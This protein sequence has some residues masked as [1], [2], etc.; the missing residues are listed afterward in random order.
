M[1]S[2]MKYLVAVILSVAL[3]GCL[4]TPS[5]KPIPDDPSYAPI[6]PAFPPPKVSSDGSLFQA[7]VTSDLYSDFRSSRI[8]DIITVVLQENTT[9]S[10]S[11]STSTSRESTVEVDPVLGLGGQV[12]NVGNG[13]N[14]GLQFDLESETEFEGDAQANQS[15]S[16]IGNISVTVVDVL[17]NNHL[18]V[19][20]EKW[21]T[22]NN[23]D[24]Y[25]RLSGI[26][27]P[28][29]VNPQNQVQSSR[30]ANAR[31]QYSGT[32]TFASAQREGWLSKFFSGPWWPF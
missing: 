11:A 29:D 30:I 1:G 20:G 7:G 9:A 26:V 14:A 24:E 25:I 28:Q 8:G 12:I 17:P 4:S 10:K 5:Q 3:G 23:G 31:I 19:R 15:N 21:L 18:V 13:A 2:S 27:R 16:L 32:G 22:L 6:I